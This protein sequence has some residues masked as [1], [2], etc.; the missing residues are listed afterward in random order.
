MLAREL[1]T[2]GDVEIVLGAMTRPGSFVRPSESGELTLELVVSRRT[3]PQLGDHRTHGVP[4]LPVAIVLDAFARLTHACRPDLLFVGCQAL[5]VL[6]GVRLTHF[7]AQGDR[8]VLRA[9]QVTN[10]DGATFAVE[11]CSLDGAKHYT[12]TTEARPRRPAPAPV[13]E[14]PE[15]LK[16]WSGE[17]YGRTLFHGPAFH[18]IRKIDGLSN[19]GGAATLASAEDLGWSRGWHVDPAI[20]DGGLQL[21]LLWTEQVLDGAS[22]PTAVDALTLYGNGLGSGKIHCILHRDTV[23]KE[24]AVSDV[25][26]VE[27]GAVVAKLRGVETHLLPAKTPPSAHPDA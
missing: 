7:D 22:L 26:F 23:D 15:G 10:G 8:F 2:A 11:L 12:A 13:P 1:S 27:D 16:A 24:R 5:K 3:H 21:A 4:V 20:V 6:R 14:R 25:L 19:A 9:R 18:A 17:V